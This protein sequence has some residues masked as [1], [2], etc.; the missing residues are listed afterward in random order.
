[1]ADITLY[2]PG[3]L[4]LNNVKNTQESEFEVPDLGD[5]HWLLRIQIKFG[6]KGIELSQTA[7][8]DSILSRFGF[9]AWNPTLLPIDQ[10]TT[11]TR[12]NPE[13]VLK[14]IKTYQSIIGSIMYLVI[15]TRPDVTFWISF[16]AQFYSAPNKLHVAAVKCCHPYIKGTRHLTFLFLYGGTMFITGF[17][18]SDYGNCID[19]RRSVSGYKFKPGNFTI[20][21]QKQKQNSVSIST[22]EAEYVALSKHANPF[23]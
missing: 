14:D 23:L 9:Q 18:D 1:M 20:S 22:T 3:V 8:I 19:S 5:L 7:Y 6:T 12:S 13:D 17:S 2:G 21:W 4:M 15:G 11:L 10:G 16:L